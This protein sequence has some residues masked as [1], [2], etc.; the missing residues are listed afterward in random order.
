M[1]AIKCNYTPDCH[2]QDHDALLACVRS[3]V[4]YLATCK[5]GIFYPCRVGYF[6]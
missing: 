4:R 5:D 2:Q 3:P 6:E 1:F